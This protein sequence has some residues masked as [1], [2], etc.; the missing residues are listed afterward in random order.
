MNFKE[1]LVEANSPL[2]NEIDLIYQRI[3]DNLDDNHIDFSKT[4]LTFNIGKSIKVSKYNNLD[5]V[6]R[7]GKKPNVRLGKDKDDR[8]AIVIDTTGKVPA[9][10]NIRKFLEHMG[11]SRKIKEAIKNYLNK[12][13]DASA[14]TDPGTSYERTKDTNQN[15]EGKYEKLMKAMD[16]KIAQVTRAKTYIMKTHEKSADA[17]KKALAGAAV[18]HLFD[19]EIGGDFGA[20]K[21]L[22]LKLPEADFIKGLN[23]ENKKKLMS[24]IESYYEHKLD[25][26]VDEDE[27]SDNTDSKNKVDT[28]SKED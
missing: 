7:Q 5:F 8:S 28:N 17:G 22:V 4:K 9:R 19:T 14:K 11:Y 23:S 24:R 13:H 21:S 26:V 15:F 3:L 1:F 27:K 6:V 18:K 25:G 2:N 10:A 16:K 20:F 12:H